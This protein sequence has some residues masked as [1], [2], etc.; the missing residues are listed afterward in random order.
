[1]Y[2][3]NTGSLTVYNQS[4]IGVFL[5][6]SGTSWSANSDSRIKK[7][8]T[9][10]SNNELDNILKLKPCTYNYI[11]DDENQKS[12]IGFIAQDVETVYPNIIENGSYSDELQDNI[13]AINTSD[14]IPY[15]IKAIQEQDEK[16]SNIVISSQIEYITN[17][18]NKINA[19]ELQLNKLTSSLKLK[20]II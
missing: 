10:L 5:S 4:G 17:L 13:K 7:N 8:I 9:Y 20:G 18:E 16:I 14:L 1:M 2:F 3:D 6:P 19:L 15:I 12:R 11:S